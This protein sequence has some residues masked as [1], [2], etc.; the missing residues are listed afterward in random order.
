MSNDAERI[1]VEDEYLRALGRAAYNFAYLEWGI[2]WLAET[3][4]PGSLRK[5]PK[6]T[7][8]KIARRFK[9]AVEAVPESDPDKTPLLTLASR[10]EALAKDR[11]RLL[12]GTPH[13]AS[14]GEQRLKYGGRHGVKDWTVDKIID[15]A[16]EVATT[17]LDSSKIFHGGRYAAYLKAA[18]DKAS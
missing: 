9:R 2:I 12:H 8:G 4:K 13:T 10:F 3:I 17:A 1:P 16:G 6:L 18:Q 11:D 5:L 7:A 14:G 15:F